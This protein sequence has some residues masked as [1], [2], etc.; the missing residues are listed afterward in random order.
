MRQG[1]GQTS[2]PK[3]DTPALARHLRDFRL[4][5]GAAQEAM[6]R[7]LSLSP[8]AHS[9]TWW[10]G[11]QTAAMRGGVQNHQLLGRGRDQPSNALA[12]TTEAVNYRARRGN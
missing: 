5:L 8:T 4:R 10:S 3:V 12:H 2:W 11:N 1:A 7:E 9:D 6:G